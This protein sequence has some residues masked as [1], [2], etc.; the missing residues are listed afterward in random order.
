MSDTTEAY[1]EGVVCGLLIAIVVMNL[2][3]CISHLVAEVL[4]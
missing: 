4:L 1:I 3:A 2:M